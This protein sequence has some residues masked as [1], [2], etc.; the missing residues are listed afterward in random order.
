MLIARSVPVS[1]G[2]GVVALTN[3]VAVVQLDVSKTLSQ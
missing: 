1:D 3:Y 2:A